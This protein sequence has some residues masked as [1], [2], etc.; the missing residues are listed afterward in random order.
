MQAIQI[1][2]LL[3]LTQGIS[4]PSVVLLITE[5]YVPLGIKQQRNK[6]NDGTQSKISV[7]CF[8]STDAYK[9]GKDPVSVADFNRLFEVVIPDQLL[10]TQKSMEML[11][12]FILSELDKK[13]PGK[14]E[15]ITL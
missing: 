9:E 14:C 5:V 15:V 3:N 4:I 1:N 7:L 10:E 13:Y 6:E 8:A 11:I 12:G 2:A